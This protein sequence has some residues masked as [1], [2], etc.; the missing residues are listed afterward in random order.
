MGARTKKPVAAVCCAVVPGLS[1][2]G[3]RAVPTVSFSSSTSSSTSG[4][5]GWLRPFLSCKALES[6][7]SESLNSDSWVA[8]APGRPNGFRFPAAGGRILKFFRNESYNPSA[9]LNWRQGR[10]VNAVCCA[11]VPGLTMIG[12]RAV[13]TVTITS[14]TTSTTTGVFGWLRPFPPIPIKEI[15]KV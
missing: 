10:P 14:T 11:V 6:L 5:F 15:L 4:V 1:L 12:T 3:S 9:A 13:P 7:F 8:R 2:I